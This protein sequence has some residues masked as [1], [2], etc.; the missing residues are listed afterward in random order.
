MKV[1]QMHY[2]NSLWVYKSSNI[3]FF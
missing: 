3:Y 1:L 2:L